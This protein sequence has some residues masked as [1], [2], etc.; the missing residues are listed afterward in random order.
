MPGD[1]LHRRCRDD[2][3]HIPRREL[4]RKQR[5]QPWLRER[6]GFGQ[7]LLENHCLPARRVRRRF[8]VI[9][10]MRR[11]RGHLVLSARLFPHRRVL[12][13]LP[14]LHIRDRV[15]LTGRQ[16]LQLP[17]AQSCPFANDRTVSSFNQNVDVLL[18]GSISLPLSPRFFF[19]DL[20][21]SSCHL[22]RFHLRARYCICKELWKWHL[23]YGWWAGA[24]EGFWIV[25]DLRFHIDHHTY[26]HIRVIWMVYSFAYYISFAFVARACRCF[27]WSRQ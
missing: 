14:T 16:A 12:V 23:R 22:R 2:R 7:L 20:A 24:H 25:F 17:Y 8:Q 6:P 5:V 21:F 15:R 1:R 18:D 10:G 13:F 11:R 9:L 26:E 19:H 3:T 4:C 27:I